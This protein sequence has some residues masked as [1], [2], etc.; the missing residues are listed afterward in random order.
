MVLPGPPIRVAICSRYP[1]R[2]DRPKGGI[3]SATVGLTTG[4]A[5]RGDVEV[6]VVTLERRVDRPVRSQDGPVTIHRLPR[7]RWPMLFDVFAGPGRRSLDTYIRGLRPDIVHFQET[8]GFGA[9]G[10]GVPVVFTVHGFDSL[11]LRAER[12]RAWWIR[13][14]LWRLAEHTGIGAHR[15]LVSIAPYVTR[16]LRDLSTGEITDIP[17]AVSGEFFAT[18]RAEERGRILFAG[19]LNPR[20]NLIAG[21]EALDLLVRAGHDVRL[22]AAGAASDPVYE[23]RIKDYIRS[24]GL[25]SRVRLLGSLPREALR[26]ELAQAGV[27]LLPSLQE[28]APMVIAEAL[29]AGVPVVASD[30]CGIPDMVDDGQTGFLIDPANPAMIA[31]RLG[32]VLGDGEL[33]AAMSGRARRVAMERWHTD[34]VAAATV[35]LYRRLIGPQQPA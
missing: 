4:L 3:E 6:H 14:P 10:Y 31:D 24:H 33:R 21:L 2:S 19:W 20:K 9:R 23:A 26:Q 1:E 34:A 5:A 25:E 8:Y 15:H 35:T 27:L 29:A 17:N 13:A 11:N 7:G 30:A 12:R 22:H 32:R 18:P 28:N 16:M